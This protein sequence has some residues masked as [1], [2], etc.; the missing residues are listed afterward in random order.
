[1]VK[2]QKE[3]PDKGKGDAKNKPPVS[4]KQKPSKV[5]IKKA[6]NAAKSVKKSTTLSKVKVRRNI[7]FFRKKTLKKPRTP[8]FPR[9]LKTRHSKKLDKYS[10]VKY[11]LTTECSMKMIEE[12]NTL[13]F[14]VDP[15]ANK[16]KIKLAMKNLYDVDCQSV[17]TLIRPDG[18]KKA[19]VR[20]SPDQDALD[21]ANKIGII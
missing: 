7:H 12:I 18:L 14:I 15:R 11:P 13:V 2:A 20:L 4:S 3:Q 21:V 16:R 1:M 9:V 5:D 8:K 17:N 6:K 10:I 19:F